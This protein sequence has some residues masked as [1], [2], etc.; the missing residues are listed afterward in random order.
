MKDSALRTG[1]GLLALTLATSARLFGAPTWIEVKSPHFTAIS[2]AGE[3]SA[4]HVLWEFEQIRAAL[5]KVWPWA[6]VDSGLPF[7]VFAVR[8]EATL[9][10]LGPQYWEGKQFR[11]I[12]FSTT[13][14]DRKLLALRTDIQEAD[15]INANPYQ[16]AYWSYVAA[17]LG[18][19]FPRQLPAWFHRGVAEVWSNSLVREHE[20]QVGR[21]I[22]YDVAQLRDGA[23]VPLAEFLSA[24]RGSRLLTGESEIQMFDA[25]AW[26][27]VHYLMF[28]E[29]G[30]NAA[31]FNR[32]AQLLMKGTEPDVALRES[33]SDPKPYYDALHRYVSQPLFPFARIA[34]SLDLKVEG[35]TRRDLGAAEAA[36]QRAS[37]LVAM[38]R[39]TEARA[40]A[41]E[42]ARADPASPG[43]A[44]IEASLCDREKKPDEAK[45]AYAMAVERG[46]TRGHVYYRLAQ[47]EFARE[48]DEAALKRRETLLRRALEL[49]PG[50]ANTLSYLA[51]TLLDLRRPEEA[52]PFAREA[53][54]K[55]P[56]SSYHRVAL[57]R[58]AWA[59]GNPDDAI[60]VARS[61][62]AA[63]D[64]DGERRYAQNYLDQ[65]LRAK[66][67]APPQP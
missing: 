31:K 21:P 60:A 45:A 55:D 4:K 59:L 23:M 27:L 48:A 62:V 11:P 5:V 47:L 37:F 63:A 30:T 56:S 49:D 36:S 2:D 29:Q 17:V 38:D 52:L 18:S 41:A 50:S 34:V 10:T 16:K 57:A 20:I 35:F 24:Q 43:P 15:E 58:V 22:R 53:I 3:G 39:P 9:R 32:F 25:Q 66:A 7:Y 26:A 46:S 28:G 54:D 61:A 65:V 8:N 14:R 33:L 51:E 64:D 12:A 13:A 6:K 40:L 67:G 19:S 42:A 1:A 44:E